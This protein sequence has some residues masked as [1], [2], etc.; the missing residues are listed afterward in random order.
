MLDA[1]PPGRSPHMPKRTRFRTVIYFL[2]G[3]IDIHCYNM[4]RLGLRGYVTETARNIQK[5]IR[6]FVAKFY[7]NALDPMSRTLQKVWDAN[8]QALE[9]YEPKV[10][11]G[12]VTLF[13]ASRTFIAYE[14]TRLA[15]SDLAA[16]GLEVHLV[17]GEHLSMREEPNVRV[18]AGK[19]RDCI[20]KA[21][22]HEPPEDTDAARR[23]KDGLESS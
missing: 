2:I 15:W 16:D 17:P 6:N 21:Q 4:M 19:L 23:G 7:P 18:L 12:R 10:Y 14:D 11:P 1:T 9:G 22:S 13:A 20:L 8:L 5:R 3:Q